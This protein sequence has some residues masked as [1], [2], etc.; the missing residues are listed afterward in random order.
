MQSFFTIYIKANDKDFYQLQ[1]F[2]PKFNYK[3]SGSFPRLFPNI[4]FCTFY[5]NWCPTTFLA[6]SAIALHILLLYLGIMCPIEIALR[7]AK[8]YN[9]F[10]ATKSAIKSFIFCDP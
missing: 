6:S 7:V 2:K 4:S 8:H 3:A 10:D 5:N 1:N 9:L